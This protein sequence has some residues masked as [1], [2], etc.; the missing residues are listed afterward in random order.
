MTRTFT[1]TFTPDAAKARAVSAPSPAEEPVMRATEA[2]V[3]LTGAA[4]A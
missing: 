1:T 2:L 3:S 4:I